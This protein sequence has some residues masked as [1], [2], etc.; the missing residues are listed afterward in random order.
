MTTRVLGGA[1]PA[2]PQVGKER[3][4]IEELSLG[5]QFRFGCRG[6]LLRLG[7]DR[8]RRVVY[9][10]GGA[11]GFSRLDFCLGLGAK[12]VNNLKRRLNCCGC[13]IALNFGT[14]NLSA[15]AMAERS[16]RSRSFSSPRSFAIVPSIDPRV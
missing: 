13:R 9:R 5:A 7:G 12:V 11:P 4:G 1:E 6:L 2:P 15:S 8:F 16:A 10:G 14:R 3:I